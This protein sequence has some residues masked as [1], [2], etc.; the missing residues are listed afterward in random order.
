[1]IQDEEPERPEDEDVRD[2]GRDD[3]A[4]FLASRD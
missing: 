4:D 1:M 3:E 2:W